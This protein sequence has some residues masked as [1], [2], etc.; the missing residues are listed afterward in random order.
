[1]PAPA[2][3]LTLDPESLAFKAYTASPIGTTPR[4]DQLAFLPVE[5]VMR[6][7]EQERPGIDL[8]TQNLTALST[9]AATSAQTS[10]QQ[11]QQ[12]QQ[13]DKATADNLALDLHVSSP[14]ATM[15][16][17][18][19]KVSAMLDAVLEYV[20]AVNAGER[21]GD[22]RVGRALLETVGVA[23]APSSPVA[24]SASAAGAPKKLPSDAK[25]FEEDFN[26]HLADVLMVSPT[27][28]LSEQKPSIVHLLIAHSLE[29]NPQVSYLANLVKTQTE[30]SSR[31]NLL[32]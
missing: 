31:L 1:M 19:L 23:P 6:V 22:E 27:S 30:L 4:P 21:Q 16:G 18:L 26:A 9:R 32:V 12:Q 2:V 13:Q 7:H 28:H 15:Y 3:H 25:S 24:S 5:S 10:H 11:Q 20:R 29:P 8:L 17:L 14:L